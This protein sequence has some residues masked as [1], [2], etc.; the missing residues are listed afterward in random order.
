MNT[1][2]DEYNKCSKNPL[3]FFN[4]YLVLK[5]FTTDYIQFNAKNFQIKAINDYLTSNKI[6]LNK[7]K[8]RQAGHTTILIALALHKMLFSAAIETENVLIRS[9]SYSS[10]EIILD[11]IMIINH[12]L[13]I[14]CP[15]YNRL[16][17]PINIKKTSLQFINGVI[18]CFIGNPNILCRGR[19]ISMILFDEWWQYYNQNDVDLNPSSKD[20]NNGLIIAKVF[21]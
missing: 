7:N 2:I 11:K 4:K 6:I 19:K 9:F 12:L 3:Y 1:Y 8:K 10:N 18:E 16:N 20:L 15:F 17:R 5:D 14:N 21:N 13:E